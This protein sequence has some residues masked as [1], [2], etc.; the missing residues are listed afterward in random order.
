MRTG[1]GTPSVSPPSSASGPKEAPAGGWSR[2][3]CSCLLYK[4]DDCAHPL[5]AP[6]HSSTPVLHPLAQVQRTKEHPPTH[7][8]HYLEGGGEKHCDRES[9]IW[10]K[11]KSSGE[12]EGLHPHSLIQL[13]L[14]MRMFCICAARYDSHQNIEQ[15]KCGWCD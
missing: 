6:G 14:V 4:A 3:G 2:I 11:E 7:R 12:L 8:G 13:S 10:E 9:L 1:P 5:G 15:S